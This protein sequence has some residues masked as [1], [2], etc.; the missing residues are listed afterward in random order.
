MNPPD[1]PCIGIC[2]LDDEEYCLGCRR[3]IGEI[4]SWSRMPEAERR[5][6]LNEL[7]QRG[8]KLPDETR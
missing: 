2:T 5:R 3:H 8:G 1:S 6:I 4:A 7:P